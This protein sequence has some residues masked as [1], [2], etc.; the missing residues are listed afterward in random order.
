MQGSKRLSSMAVFT[1]Q[2]KDAK[3]EFPSHQTQDTKFSKLP[4]MP[5]YNHHFAQNLRLK[6]QTRYPPTR[7][8]ITQ[9]R[10]LSGALSSPVTIELSTRQ[11]KKNRIKHGRAGGRGNTL[12][13][14]VRLALT[15]A[16]RSRGWL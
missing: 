14:W 9:C 11:K 10:S 16:G 13:A 8:N 1:T 3:S 2:S 7:C 12:A 4:H 15:G 6:E 5:L